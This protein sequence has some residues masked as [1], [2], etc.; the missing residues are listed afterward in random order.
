MRLLKLFSTIIL[1]IH[2]NGCGEFFSSEVYVTGKVGE[3]L[4]VCDDAIWNSSI[5]SDLD[6][7]LTR[8]IMPYFPDVA[9]FEL[10]HYNDKN[11]VGAVKRHR[12]VLFLTIDQNHKGNKGKLQYRDD[13]WANN[14]LVIEIIAK[15]YTQLVQ[16]INAGADHIHEKF[17]YESWNRIRKRFAEEKN[18]RIDS[19]L[20]QNFGVHIDLPNASKM[21]SSRKNFCRIELPAASRPIEFVGASKQDLGTIFSGIMV[22]QYPYTDSSQLGIDQLLK[23]RDTMLK[24]N[25]PHETQGLYMGTQY[26]EFVY[27][28]SSEESNFKETINGIEVRGMFEFKGRF[29]HSTGGAFWSFHFLQPKTNQL[30]CVSGYVDAPSSTSWTHAIREIQAI[31]K[32]VT[33]L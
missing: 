31:W 27:P 8:F 7:N 4:V 6:S 32:S 22:Y 13:V 20:K 16:T 11:F 15:D 23:A 9:T 12:N 5:H 29:Q 24:Y 1:A 18:N 30:V 28:H 21:V 10:L 14:Q 3:I 19:E 26:N 17:E 25:V 33:I 2:L